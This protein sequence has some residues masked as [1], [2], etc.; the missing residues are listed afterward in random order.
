MSSG[1]SGRRLA[2]GDTRLASDVAS[3]ITG[4]IPG[5]TPPPLESPASVRPFNTNK[6]FSTKI[7]KLLQ[8]RRAMAGLTSEGLAFFKD[9][10]Y[11]VIPG[12]L[13]PEVVDEL[14]KE[15]AGLLEG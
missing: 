4:V 9:N 1:G 12:A 15:T 11:L 3:L 10:G 6:Y 14:K 13:S 2:A 8:H 7:Y 5:S